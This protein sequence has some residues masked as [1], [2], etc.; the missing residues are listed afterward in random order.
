MASKVTNNAVAGDILIIEELAKHLRYKKEE[1]EFMIR[2][3]KKGVIAVESLLEEAISKVGKLKRCIKDGQDFIDSSDAKKA[4][5]GLISNFDKNRGATIG[6]VKGKNGKL[7]VMVADPYVKKGLYYFVIPNHELKGKHNIKIPFHKD[8]GPP[9]RFL[10]LT[11]LSTCT[12]YFT[13]RLWICYQVKNF[14]EMCT[15]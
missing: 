2:L 9:N 6:N 3:A 11:C 8:G 12:E 7:R 5:V 10:N 14:H 15:K 4:T 13:D 1:R